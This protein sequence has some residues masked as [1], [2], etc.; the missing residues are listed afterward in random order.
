MCKTG[1]V[2]PLTDEEFATLAARAAMTGIEIT[3]RGADIFNVKRSESQFWFRIPG[4]MYFT[5]TA[6]CRHLAKEVQDILQDEVPGVTVKATGR[7][8]RTVAAPMP[9]AGL[10]LR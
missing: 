5:R 2:H 4:E 1:G 3:Q 7:W 8:F 9:Q 6:G 10:I